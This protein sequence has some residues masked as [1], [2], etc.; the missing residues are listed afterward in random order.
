[1]TQSPQPISTRQICA[2]IW[3]GIAVGIVLGCGAAYL[4]LTIPVR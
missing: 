2:C 3:A 1:M 4:T